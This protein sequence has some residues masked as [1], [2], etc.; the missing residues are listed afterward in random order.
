MKVLNAIATTLKKCIMNNKTNKI[1][2][3]LP[4]Q[5]KIILICFD[6]HIQFYQLDNKIH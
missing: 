1:L 6:Q 2:K 4:K 3:M 5:E